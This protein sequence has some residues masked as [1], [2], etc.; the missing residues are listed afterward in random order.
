MKRLSKVKHENEIAFEYERREFF[1]TINDFL[2]VKMMYTH[3]VIS[4][5]KYI[6]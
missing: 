2:T 6:D 4:Q 1:S 5:N 3:S